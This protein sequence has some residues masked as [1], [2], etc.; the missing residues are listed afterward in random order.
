MIGKIFQ[1]ARD[2]P[3]KRREEKQKRLVI[4]LLAAGWG[5]LTRDERLAVL[6]TLSDEE[7]NK[8]NDLFKD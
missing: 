7:L 3:K 4:G 2:F 5:L 1:Y 6:R 8:L